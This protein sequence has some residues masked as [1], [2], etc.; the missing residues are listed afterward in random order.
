MCTQLRTLRTA[1]C[2]S[3]DPY[4]NYDNRSM[5]LCNDSNP[6]R[7]SEASFRDKNAVSGVDYSGYASEG[8]GFGEFNRDGASHGTDAGRSG[9]KRYGESET[10]PG[11]QKQYS[12]GS[13]N[14]E[15]VQQ[16][17]R[18]SS[19]SSYSG[20]SG[21]P[22]LL[23]PPFRKSDSVPSYSQQH[24]DEGKYGRGGRT[25]MGRKSPSFAGQFSSRGGSQSG[26]RPLMMIDTDR[27]RGRG[28]GGGGY[29]RGHYGKGSW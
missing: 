20:S 16:P 27:G 3:R 8:S 26:P 1:S 17:H 25:S 23:S 18:N 24:S 13:D 19:S 5:D 11:A 12:Y 14:G 22:S 21:P 2:E 4:A 29:G 6:E 10:R 15:T 7:P 9:Y 28:G